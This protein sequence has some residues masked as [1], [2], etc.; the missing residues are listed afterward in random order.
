MNKFSLTAI[1]GLVLAA[2]GAHASDPH[3]SRHAEPQTLQHTV[4][5]APVTPPVTVVAQPSYGVLSQAPVPAFGP[6]L[7][8]FQAPVGTEVQG[9]VAYA[10][11]VGVVARQV[12][13]VG[14]FQPGGI[15]AFPSLSH[16]YVVGGVTGSHQIVVNSPILATAPAI[17]PFLAR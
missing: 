16:S 12:P 14:V 4:P 9:N 13:L 15:A 10:P 7:V 17:N 1:I 2:S 6:G 11:V 5:H 3:P 8:V